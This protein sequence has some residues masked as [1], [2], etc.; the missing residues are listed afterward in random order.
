[1]IEPSDLVLGKARL[2]AGA[3]GEVWPATLHGTPVA[4]KK[5]HRNKINELNPTAFR[6]ECELQ[7]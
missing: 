4:V 5:L 3:Y 6:A 7:S 2:G 1:M